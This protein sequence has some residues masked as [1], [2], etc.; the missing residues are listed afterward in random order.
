MKD[1]LIKL[2]MVKNHNEI[3]NLKQKNKENNTKTQELVDSYK[4]IVSDY[5]NKMQKEIKQMNEK[6]NKIEE[7]NINLKMQCQFYKDCLDKIPNFI[8]RIFVGKNKKLLNK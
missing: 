6:I 1:V 8:V 3:V 2:N 7:D 4:K 5:E